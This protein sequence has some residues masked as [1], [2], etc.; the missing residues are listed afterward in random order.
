MTTIASH[1]KINWMLRVLFRR[2]DGF[3]E[4]ETIFQEISLH[5]ALHIERSAAFSLGCDDPSV[6][7]DESNLVTRAW[8]ALRERFGIDPVTIHLEKRIPAG[9]GLGGGSSNAAAALIALCEMFA[10][11]APG[12]E[13]SAI[14]LN[15]GSDVPFF[16][17]GGCAYGRGRGEELTALSSAPAVPLLLLLPGARVMTP[18]AFRLIAERRAGARFEPSMSPAVA[19]AVMSDPLAN[20]AALLNDL[21]R[22]VFD[23][24]PELEE[25]KQVLLGAGAAWA[26]MSG[27]G[28]TIVGAFEDEAARDAAARLCEERVKVVRA[29]TVAG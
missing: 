20:T 2:P 12:D 18:E 10:I 9:G 11:D 14:A 16:L 26:A 25:L 24:L 19:E 29:E 8:S 15:L 4:L 7:V 6:P 1:A 28:S 5:D 21:E 3:H 27:S 22:V 23:R 17:R 13:L